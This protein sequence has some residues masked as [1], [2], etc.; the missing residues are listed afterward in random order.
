M[1]PEKHPSYP[2]LRLVSSVPPEWESEEVFHSG[3]AFF[4]AL[5]AEFSRARESILL[6][7]YIF[8]LDSLG[9]RMLEALKDAAARGVKVRVMVDGVGSPAWSRK[10]LEELQESGVEARI[11]RPYP[12]VKIGF[13]FF[14]KLLNFRQV[15]RWLQI[16]N[17]RDHRKVAVIDGKTAWLGSFNITQVHLQEFAGDAAWRDSG[18]RVEGGEIKILTEAFE[19]AWGRAW[20]PYRRRKW[21][22][23]TKKARRADFLNPQGLV[24]LNFFPLLRRRNYEGLLHRIGASRRRVWIT[25]AYFVPE[26]PLLRALRVAAWGGVE[27]KVL[28]PV[29]SDVRF[30]RWLTMVV[31]YGLLRAG[32][33][34]YQYVPHVLHAKSVLIDDWATIG[35]SNLNHRSLH[36]DLEVDVVVR[37]SESLA[38]L[39]KQ[40]LRD[41]DF[42]EQVTLE[43]WRHKFWL[44]RFLGRLLFFLRYW[45]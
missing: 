19:K 36:H 40:F 42:S 29:K 8:E 12:W 14:P 25:S 38:S 35:S 15:A 32:V 24:R 44:E 16:L 10:I 45:M 43:K 23:K 11:F 9:L 6:E 13:R 37:R 21:F 5:L 4:S 30:V 20:S 41:L 26:R 7:T 2:P 39:E 18:V 34:V 31:V 27:V 33:E 17:R 3:D 1:I 22:R 28:I